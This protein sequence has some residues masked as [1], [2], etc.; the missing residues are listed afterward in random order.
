[1][2]KIP[3]SSKDSRFQNP[4]QVWDSRDLGCEMLDNLVTDSFKVYK[5]LI[6]LIIPK[7]MLRVAR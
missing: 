5:K 6:P 7:R 3:D 4:S 1:M 2:A